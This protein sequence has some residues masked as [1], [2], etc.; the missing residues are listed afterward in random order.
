MRKRAP[1]V[2]FGFVTIVAATYLADMAVLRV[3]TNPTGTV[4]VHPYTAVPRNDKREELMFDEPRDQTCVNS[5]F[6]HRQMSPCWYLRRHPEIRTS[7]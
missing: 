6:P 5:L 1:Y 4:T 7:L 2:L 3:R